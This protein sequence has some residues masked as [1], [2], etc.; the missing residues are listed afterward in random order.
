[1]TRFA[2]LDDDDLGLIPFGSLT[3]E[4]SDSPIRQ[5]VVAFTVTPAWAR[6]RYGFVE[7]KGE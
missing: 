5:L 3:V 7:I 6:H 4:V 2:E 1:M